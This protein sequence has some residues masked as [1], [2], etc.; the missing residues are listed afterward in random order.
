MTKDRYMRLPEVAALTGVCEA[1]VERMA[2]DDDCDFPP[3]RRIGKRAVGFLESE[4]QKWIRS[5]PTTGAA[6]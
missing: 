4:I 6:R 3:P 2:N 5:R 1:T